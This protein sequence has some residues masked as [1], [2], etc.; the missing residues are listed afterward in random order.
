MLHEDLIK[1]L[2]ELST[3]PHGT[4][5]SDSEIKQAELAIELE[6]P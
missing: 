1:R 4:G 3:N 5:A 2:S 6:L